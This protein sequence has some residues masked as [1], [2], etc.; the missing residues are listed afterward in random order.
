MKKG[1]YFLMTFPAMNDKAPSN[2]HFSM[3]TKQPEC[4]G[5][6]VPNFLKIAFFNY[7]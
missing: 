6:Q 5:I 4:Q 3:F 1:T 2:I 7:F